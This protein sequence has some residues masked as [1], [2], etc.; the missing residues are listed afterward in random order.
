LLL[1]EL[2]MSC[3]TSSI[4]FC[5]SFSSWICRANSRP[6][7]VAGR[8]WT[9]L[10]HWMQIDR[11]RLQK[12][13]NAFL[14]SGDSGRSPDSIAVCGPSAHFFFVKL[15]D[16]LLNEFD[17]LIV[18]WVRFGPSSQNAPVRRDVFIVYGGHLFTNCFTAPRESVRNGF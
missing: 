8:H 15:H 17:H 13:G 18:V 5:G 4:I 12:T 7:F 2:G 11:R 16:H 6:I 1:V 10:F 14:H 9:F 3:W